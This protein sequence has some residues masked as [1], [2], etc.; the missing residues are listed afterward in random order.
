MCVMVEEAL[1]CLQ[2]DTLGMRGW[3]QAWLTFLGEGVDGNIDRLGWEVE[4]RAFGMDMPWDCSRLKEVWRRL[5]GTPIWVLPRSILPWG[6]LHTHRRG[7]VRVIAMAEVPRVLRG[8][9]EV[10]VISCHC[11]RL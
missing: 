5:V 4:R 9:S 2:S 1:V 10:M 8:D 7:L 11:L 6:W 3:A